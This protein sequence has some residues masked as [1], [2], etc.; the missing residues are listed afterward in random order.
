MFI[1]MITLLHN[2]MITRLHIHIL[3][4]QVKVSSNLF[5]FL[6]HEKKKKIDEL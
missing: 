2:Y 4:T 3:V 5:T 6:I 1:D